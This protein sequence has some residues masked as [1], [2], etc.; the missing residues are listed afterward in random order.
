MTCCQCKTRFRCLPDEEGDHACPKCGY[1]PENAM[2][3]PNDDTPH[4]EATG[5]IHRTDGELCGPC[6]REALADPEAWE[7]YGDHPA[8]IANWKRLQKEMDR[9]SEECAAIPRLPADSDD[10]PF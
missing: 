3:D 6:Y 5:C 1:H 8:G 4:I 7:E 2:L 10:L 9:Y